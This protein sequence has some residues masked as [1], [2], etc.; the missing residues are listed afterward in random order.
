MKISGFKTF[1]HKVEIDFQDGITA[2]VGPNGVGKSNLIDALNWV[3]GETRL[4]DLRVRSSEQLIFHGSPNLKPLSL[5]EVSLT[6]ENH[7]GMLPVEFSEVNITRRIHRDGTS[8]LYLNKSKCILKDITNLFLGTGSGRG[9]YSSMRQGEIDRILRQKPEER[10]EI[11]EEAAGVLKYRNRRRETKRELERAETNLKQIRPTLIEVERQY[12]GKKKQAERAKRFSEVQDRRIN[13]E[14]DLQ[15]IRIMELKKEHTAKNG[16]LLKLLEKKQAILNALKGIEAEIDTSLAESKDLLQRQD[17]IQS[18]I[19]QFENKLGTARQRIAT[20]DERRMSLEHGIREWELSLRQSNERLARMDTAIADLVTEKSNLDGIVL[21]R[22]DNLEQYAEDIKSILKIL[23]SDKDAITNYRKKIQDLD[24]AL[25]AARARH[26]EVINR[27]VDAIDKRKAELKG[28]TELKQD[29]KGTIARSLDELSVFLKGR[30]DVLTDLANLDFTRHSD[31]ETIRSTLLAFRESMELRLAALEELR[32]QFAQLDNLISGFD[33]I[34]FAREGIHAQKEAIDTAISDM[35]REEKAHEERI[36]F[37]ETD[38]KNQSGKT[39]TIREMMH[40]TQLA[41]VQM[42]EKSKALDENIMVQRNFRADI[43]KQCHTMTTNIAKANETIAE[44][45][46]EYRAQGKEQTDF[47]SQQEKHREELH[48][49]SKNLSAITNTSSGKEKKARELKEQL[50]ELHSR[51]DDASKAVTVIEVELRTIHEIFYENY[52]IDLAEREKA[53]HNRTF[54]AALLRAD[55]KTIKDELRDIGQVNPIAIDECRELE[56]RFTLLREQVE[57]IEKSA[58]NLEAIIK[59][60]NKNSEELFQETFNKVRI[61]FHKIFRRLFDGGRAEIRLT[62]PEN[63]LESGVEIFVQP[64]KKAMQTEAL[65]SG[66]ESSLTAIALLFAIFMVHPS[67]F[68]LLD[69]IDAALDKPNI[70]RFKKLLLEFRDTTQ[71]LIIS[72]NIATL[73]AADALY[74]ISMEEDGVSTALSIDINELERNR[75]KYELE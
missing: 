38:I 20:L 23:E 40:G 18:E 41:L 62:N 39:E 72:H 35:Q 9:A 63:M 13:I 7:E 4:S 56:E 52:S 34:I 65:L 59:D 10:R 44:I 15:L 45:E 37:L 75:K 3:T 51:I 69:E 67:P 46:K 60:I 24:Q 74:G 12:A 1:G 61:N 27:M 54:D 8:E 48:R 6:I 73:K 14:V 57:D 31:K 11:F 33:E 36:L 26:E 55:L 28:S 2:I 5:A 70:E 42:R 50:E 21:E 64:P 68:C 19:L 47:L 71:F 22:Q 43:E 25:L 30:K 17:H 49:I 58:K 53:I 32:K 16:I 29:L 66:G